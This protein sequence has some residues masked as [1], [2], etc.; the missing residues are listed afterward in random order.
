MKTIFAFLLTLSTKY[1][2]E[3]S[4]L[5]VIEIFCSG[6]AAFALALQPNNRKIKGGFLRNVL[7][8][9]VP[10]GIT[11]ALGVFVIVMLIPWI[12][13]KQPVTDINYLEMPHR[14]S[15]TVGGLYL[16]TLGILTLFYHCRPLNKYRSI[17]FGVMTIATL[18]VCFTPLGEF[19]AHYYLSLLN[20]DLWILY[21]V[22]TICG[23]LLF[24]LS[25]KVFDLFI[26]KYEERKKN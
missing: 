18:V 20:K 9:A 17:I 7:S 8:K 14:F 12:M 2:F 24:I 25:K 11:Y 10:G 4:N 13:N 19:F 21:V 3:P 1:P 6:L 22:A 15:Q 23:A 5:M 26:K 16:S